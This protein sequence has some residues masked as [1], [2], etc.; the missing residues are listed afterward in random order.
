VILDVEP[1]TD[2]GTGAIVGK[3]LPSSALMIVNGM[4]YP[5]IR[6]RIYWNSLRS[7]RATRM[8]E[9]LRK[10]RPL[11]LLGSFYGRNSDV[12]A[13]GRTRGW[14]PDAPAYWLP[15]MMI[16]DADRAVW[17]RNSFLEKI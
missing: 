4:S 2:I 14:Q 9:A 8:A 13:G 15:N 1:V 17:T 7:E 5:E 16:E 3:G 11:A 10:R 6:D 12:P